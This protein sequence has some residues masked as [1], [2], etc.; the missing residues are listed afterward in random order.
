MI[1]GVILACEI[2][3][4]VVIAAGLT[5]RYPL[6][7]PRAGLV[8]LA[9]VP[10]VDVVLLVATAWHLRGGATATS[11]H[12]LAAFYLGFSVAYGHRVIRWADVRFAHRFAGGPA[13]VRLAGAAYARH[14]WADVGRTAVAV[15]VASAITW[16]LVAWVDAPDRT[17]AFGATYGWGAAI[18]AIGVLYAASYTVWPRAARPQRVAEG[19]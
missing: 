4:W 1:I 12:T 10:V 9:L 7:R 14:C 16:L 5:L 2:A 18:L 8:A 17:A 19:R 6:R 11:A 13:P 15:A 3:F